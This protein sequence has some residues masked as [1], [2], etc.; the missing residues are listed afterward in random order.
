MT[1]IVLVH[2]G[3]V[4]GIFGS[5]LAKSLV[6]VEQP[7]WCRLI[8]GAMINRGFSVDIIDAEAENL[9]ADDV[10]C[11]VM[12]VSP[13]LVAIVVSG[14]QPSASSQQMIGASKIAKSIRYRAHSAPII[15]L[16]NHPSALPERTL[17]EETVDYVCDGEGPTTLEGLLRGQELSEIQGLVWWDDDGSVRKNPLASLLNLNKDFHGNVWHMLKMPLY[18]SHNWHRFGNLSK[19][20]PYAAIYTSLGCS[21]RCSFCM[22]NVFQHTNRYRMR[23]PKMVVDEMVMLNRDY[24][25]ETFKFVDELFV[26]NRRHCEA[27]CNGIIEAGLGDRISSWCYSRIDTVMSGML[28]LF[29]RAGFD[30]FA[31]GIESGSKYVRDGADKRL[32]ND[33]I[34][35]VVRTIQ[36]A[37]IN[38]IG[39]YIFGLPDDTMESMRETLNLALGLNTEFANMYSAQAYPGSPL[40]DEAVKKSWTLPETWAGYSQHNYECRPLD[41]QH[42]SAAQV[43]KFRDEAFLTYFRNPRYQQMVLEKFGPETLEHVRQMTKYEL[44]RKLLDDTFAPKEKASAQ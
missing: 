27:I 24:G 41:T 32:K 8:A 13:A 9:D 10:A 31:L 7:L 37:G 15:M 21:Y 14:H 28:P 3:A 34:E 44:K 30:W 42:I 11:R 16:G 22:I 26:L 39:N 5:D 43:L 18:R 19:R 35:S 6:A 23:D 36:M 12:H 4:H 29:R 25:V 20:Q 2:P 1:D 40:Y 38:V 33:D 17:R